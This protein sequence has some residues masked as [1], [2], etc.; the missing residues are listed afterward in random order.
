MGLGVGVNNMQRPYSDHEVSLIQ[1]YCQTVHLKYCVI[2]QARRKKNA[3]SKK[4]IEVMI[5]VARGRSTNDISEKMGLSTNTINTHL[6]R[7][8]HKL[9]VTDRVS[10]TL[11][12][13]ALGYIYE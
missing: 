7:I 6:K 13:L 3:L 4:E 8:Y 2:T 5:C 10:A 9:D 12:F 11:R 1:A